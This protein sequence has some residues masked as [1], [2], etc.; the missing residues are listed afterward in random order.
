MHRARVRWAAVIAGAT[1][2]G[3][4]SCRPSTPEAPHVN[5]TSVEPLRAAFN[6][7]SG[8]VRAIFLASPT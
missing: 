6:R 4:A 5:L 2:A 7:D 8:K 3:V 1:V